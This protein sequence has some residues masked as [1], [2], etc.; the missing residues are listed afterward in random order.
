MPVPGDC[1]A[2]GNAMAV[3]KANSKANMTE[4]GKDSNKNEP[5]C[6]STQGGHAAYEMHVAAIK[7]LTVGLTANSEQVQQVQQILHLNLA[8]N[9]CYDT[10]TALLSCIPSCQFFK[11]SS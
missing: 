4:T 3:A 2:P 7:A 10:G 8:V 9:A 5:T 6:S 11:T 1:L